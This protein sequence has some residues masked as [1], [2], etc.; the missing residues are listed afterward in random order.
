M[1][2]LESIGGTH[3]LLWYLRLPGRINHPLGVAWAVN[4]HHH[5]QSSTHTVAT[6][7]VCR[8]ATPLPSSPPSLATVHSP[9]AVFTSLTWFHSSLKAPEE[10][11][12]SGPAKTSEGGGERER[13]RE[14]RD[15]KKD[16]TDGEREAREGG[17]EI[18]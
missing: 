8:A 11:R 7:S 9:T 16:D 5:H 6:G 17:S 18:K 4:H 3:L 14:W 13:E 2:F 12:A 15:G 10:G 1:G